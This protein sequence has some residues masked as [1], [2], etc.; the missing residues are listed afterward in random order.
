MQLFAARTHGGASQIRFGSIS[1]HQCSL[2]L[3]QF[4]HSKFFILGQWAMRCYLRAT[5][6]A[7]V[8][9]TRWKCQRCFMN[10]V[11]V[12]IFCMQTLFFLKM[13]IP[14]NLAVIAV[15]IT[16]VES[17]RFS[18]FIISTSLD[19][20]FANSLSASEWHSRRAGLYR[21]AFDFA[22]ELGLGR[23]HVGPVCCSSPIGICMKMVFVW[24][25][26]LLQTLTRK[27]YLVSCHFNVLWLLCFYFSV[28]AYTAQFRGESAQEQAYVFWVGHANHGDAVHV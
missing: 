23:T 26:S 6:I 1:Q 8:F 11:T 9:S 20:V 13:R 7:I 21:A 25:F 3:N 18:F 10:S 2:V 19:Q 4:T 17:I 14:S 27:V 22:G 12:S 28:A 15:L 16:T 24:L 5:C